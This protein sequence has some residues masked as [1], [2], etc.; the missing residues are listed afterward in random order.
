MTSD[1][2]FLM[3]LTQ[4]HALFHHLNPNNPFVMY[5]LTRFS[6]LPAGKTKPTIYFGACHYFGAYWCF[7][8]QRISQHIVYNNTTII[9][10]SFIAR[11]RI[12]LQG[13]FT[14]FE[15]FLIAFG[16]YLPAAISLVNTPF[17]GNK[18]ISDN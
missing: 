12:L 17:P 7:H 4:F 3:E 5:D 16:A 14:Y 15:A 6:S 1:G 8:S 18:I 11:R 13:G 2:L 9:L 10:A